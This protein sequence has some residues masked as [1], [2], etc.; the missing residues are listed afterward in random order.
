MH[1]LKNNIEAFNSLV[2]AA[3]NATANG[4]GYDAAKVNG[5]VAVVSVGALTDGTHTFKLQESDDNST[6]TDVAVGDLIGSFVAVT[7]NSVQRVGYIGIKRYVRVVQT[8]SGATTGAIT[9]AQV[10]GGFPRK[11]PLP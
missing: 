11:Y 8:V 3:R 5:V 10:I 4:T 7:A 9:S 6:F 2:P 1:D